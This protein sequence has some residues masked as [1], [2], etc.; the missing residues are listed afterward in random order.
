MAL[1]SRSEG[2]LEEIY[3]T[4][5][6]FLNRYVGTQLYGWGTNG[7]GQLGISGTTTDK[8]TPIQVGTIS[9]WKQISAG[10]VHSFGVKTD[11]TM[12]G[13]GSNG[14][15]ELGD[16]TAI[17]RSSPVQ[18]VG[19]ATTWKTVSAGYQS[20]SAIKTDGTLWL[21]GYNTSYGQLGDNTTIHKSSPVQVHGGGTWRQSFCAVYYSGGV[22]TDGSLWTWGIN[23]SGCLGDGSLTNRSSPVQVV[24]GGNN[25]K[26]VHGGYY[27]TLGLKTDGSLWAWGQNSD[28]Q[29]GDN[30]TAHKS[31][32]IQVIGGYTWKQVT[33]SNYSSFGIKTDGTL[34]GWGND[35]N[36][37]LGNGTPGH[38]SSPIQVIGNATNWKYIAHSSPGAGSVNTICAIKTDGTLWVWGYNG[39]G[40]IGDNTLINRSS[41]V[42]TT[43]GGSNWKQCWT[44]GNHTIALAI[45]DLT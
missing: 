17:N 24:G 14:F 26:F 25:W 10:T 13:C 38:R 16:N 23:S 2:N 12:W 44:T 6:E 15:G 42:Q 4:E 39:Y 37:Q 36:G 28:G 34:W 18:V 19:N 35:L 20:T 22:K 31:S 43:L 27:H 1:T 40:A 41:P 45:E 32:P 8:S 29:L 33:T 9:T 7:S 5:E 11:G 21:W 3:L 30:T